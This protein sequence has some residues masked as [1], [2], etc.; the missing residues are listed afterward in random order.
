MRM[1]MRLKSSPRKVAIG[2]AATSLAAVLLVTGNLPYAHSSSATPKPAPP[3]PTGELADA[4]GSGWTA[5][6]GAEPPARQPAVAGPTK[7]AA[8]KAGAPDDCTHFPADN[9]WRADISG[10]PVHPRSGPILATTQPERGVHTDFGG[11]LDDEKQEPFGIPI[12]PVPTGTPGRKVH[13]GYDDESDEGPYLIPPGALIEGG[14]DSDGDRHIIA[15]DPAG[16][17]VY[18]L[19]NVWP[20]DDGD[21]DADSGAIFDLRSNQMRTI[22][23]TSADAAGLSIYAGLVRFDEV[24]AGFVGHA[25]RVTFANSR[26]E[27]VWPGS[28][29]AST[30]TDP[31]LPP[32]G[33]R[34]RLKADV[35]ISGLPPQARVIAQALKQY[36]AIMADNGSN[37]FFS[38]AHDPRWDDDQLRTLKTTLH[39]TD[40]EVV[41]AES[42]KVS[43]DSYAVRQPS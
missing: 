25:L 32:M 41:D 3:P 42:L 8:K 16:C 23:H 21:W 35:D 14:P 22:G 6:P 13:F 19:F 33:L 39:G 37:W 30:K 26:R 18:E 28:H 36:G 4:P 9:V 38:G 40:F 1:P 34:I 24:A 2:V 10:L 29:F 31:D 5:I 17:K 15:H 43:D 11:F 12:T 27:F 20:R 7:A